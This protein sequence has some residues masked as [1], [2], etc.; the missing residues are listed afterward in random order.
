MASGQWLHGGDRPHPMTERPLNILYVNLEDDRAH[1]QR[2]FVGTAGHFQQYDESEG[3]PVYYWGNPPKPHPYY[4]EDGY[5]QYPTVPLDLNALGRKIIV[6]SGHNGS[7]KIAELKAGDIRV[8][9][10]LVNELRDWVKAHKI[11]VIVFDPFIGLHGLDENSNTHVDAV[12]KELGRLASEANCAIELVHHT[13]KVNGAE[14]NVESIRG[15]SAFVNAARSARILD[16]MSE[17]EAEGWGIDPDERRLYVYQCNAKA[18]LVLPSDKKLWFKLEGASVG[19]GNYE[20]DPDFVGVPVLWEPPPKVVKELYPQEKKQ[21]LL[22]IF[23]AEPPP[24]KSDQTK[25]WAGYYIAD[26]LNLDRSQGGELTPEANKQATKV[27]EALIEE[28]MVEV[29]K[30]KDPKAKRE[31]PFLVLSEAGKPE[32][33]PPF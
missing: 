16:V 31:V 17:T 24:K 7:I 29:I 10:K 28:K 1:I 6:H 23:A 18:N 3:A 22:A 32:L 30:I 4:W 20:H 2:K 11:D 19:N 15:A 13:R 21:V 5:P 14:Q 25:E 33:H 12:M 9:T 8:W 27:I 26:A